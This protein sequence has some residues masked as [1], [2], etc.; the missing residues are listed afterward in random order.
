VTFKALTVQRENIF[1]LQNLLSSEDNELFPV[2][3]DMD[4]E[5][6]ILCSA[7]ATRKYCVDYNNLRIVRFFTPTLLTLFLLLFSYYVL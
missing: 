1:N 6:Y 5:A 4:I 2:R 7:A 3:V